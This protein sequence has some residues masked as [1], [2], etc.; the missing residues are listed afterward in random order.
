MAED[1]IK[2]LDLQP[3]PYGGFFKE[4]HRSPLAVKPNDRD[5]R[6]AFT[7]IY[8]VMQ[9]EDI[10]PWHKIKSE[11]TFFYHKGA[12]LKL[13]TIDPEGKL[14]TK[15]VG[16]PTVDPEAVFACVIPAGVWFAG[17]LVDRENSYGFF[18]VVVSP[19]FHFADSEVAHVEKLCEQFPDHKELIER[20][21][22]DPPK[23]AENE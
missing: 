11:E 7:C 14:E 18:S 17:E 10:D 13:F 23:A 19:G 16:D 5:A 1:L 2:S 9:N 3:H 8:L 6:S 15:I 20:L 21:H 22:L 4:V 12:F